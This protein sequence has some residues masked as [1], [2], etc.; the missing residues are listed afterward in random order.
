MYRFIGWLYKTILILCFSIS[1]LNMDVS[2]S[3]E[4][5]E[6]SPNLQK[7][8]D[9]NVQFPQIIIFVTKLDGRF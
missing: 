3:T 9:K 1:Q 5:Q 2:P 7:I 8:Y 4:L 6:K